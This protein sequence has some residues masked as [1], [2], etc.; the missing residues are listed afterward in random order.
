[1][2]TTRLH[3][4]DTKLR[5]FHIDF[6]VLAGFLLQIPKY[7][8]Q[9]YPGAIINIHPALLPRFG[10]KGMYG[11]HVHKAV[12][13]AGEKESGITIHYVNEHYDSGAIIHQEKC[14][15]DPADTYEDVARKVHRLEYEFYPRIIEDI[16]S[17]L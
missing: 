3:S 10:G 13:E 4:S 6:I 5:D 17:R 15:V 11:D 14:A 7:L 8:I 12:V 9:A 16:V 1:M 2:Y